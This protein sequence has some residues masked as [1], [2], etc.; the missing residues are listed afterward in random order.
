MI[1]ESRLTFFIE[2]IK[3]D[4]GSVQ[5]RQKEAK[6]GSGRRQESA[7]RW[8]PDSKTI[9]CYWMEDS[10]TLQGVV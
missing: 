6:N 10:S 2:R 1:R 7:S 9:Y 5:L 8:M 3:E 4:G